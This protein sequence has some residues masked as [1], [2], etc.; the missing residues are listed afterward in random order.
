MRVICI[1]DTH[2][3]HRVIGPN[4]PAG[5]VIIH[6][7]DF[8]NRGSMDEA[9]RGLGWFNALPYKH[10]IIIAGNHDL[11]MDTSHLDF[12]S[13]ESAIDAILPKAE[14]FHYLLDS[15]C[16]IDGV[17]FWGSPWQPAFFNWAFNI[18]RG[19]GLQ[20]KWDLI[21]EGTDVV[22]THGP[23]YGRLDTCPDLANPKEMVHVGCMNL[24][25]TFKH[26]VKPRVHV[27]G[28]IHS[29]HGMAQEDGILFI[30]AS[31]CTESYS[32]T[33]KPFSFDI[34]PLSKAVTPI[35]FL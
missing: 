15:G 27:H 30:N 33:N 19:R 2:G 23:S 13:S 34:D 12:P 31:I 21:P 10:R 25:K 20:Q 28:H 24:A 16:T 1:S 7:G 17:T 29:G 3:L 14:G 5:D 35:T 22:I 32:P 9:I 26:R 11:F 18:P 6:A 8:C 4:L